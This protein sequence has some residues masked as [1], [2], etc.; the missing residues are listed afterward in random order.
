LPKRFSPPHATTTPC[1][2][3][4]FSFVRSTIFCRARAL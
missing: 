1:I 2:I 3:I 4:V